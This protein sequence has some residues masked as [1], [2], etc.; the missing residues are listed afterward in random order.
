MSKLSYFQK[1]KKKKPCFDRLRLKLHCW[2]KY[3]SLCI[4]RKVPQCFYWQN[5][6]NEA[7]IGKHLQFL[8]SLPH[9]MDFGETFN[10]L[11][12][13]A[14]VRLVIK[15][16]RGPRS[17][18]L[19]HL[20]LQAS[21]CLLIMLKTL[22]AHMINPNQITVIVN[23]RRTFRLT[24]LSTGSSFIRLRCNLEAQSKYS[25]SAPVF[26]FYWIYIIWEGH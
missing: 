26:L 19:V 5:F 25:P 14:V 10:C 7:F 1:K 4:K 23:G 17:M 3:D 6:F 15:E 11:Y 13:L 9:Q 18:L 2:N 20:L 8:F 22:G 12:F 24:F 21:R 16:A